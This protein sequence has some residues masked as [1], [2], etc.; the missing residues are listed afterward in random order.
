MDSRSRRNQPGSRPDFPWYNFPRNVNT[1]I[2]TKWNAK[3]DW[4]KQRMVHVPAFVV[5]YWMGSTG[6][7]EAMEPF[8]DKVFE[9]IHGPF[10]CMGW[11]RIFQIQETVYKELVMEFLST[12]SFA[13]KTGIYADDNLTFCLGGERRTLSLADFSIRIGI[14]LP[15]EVDSESYQ[16]YI[17]DC[18]RDIEGFKAEE[19]WYAIANDN[20]L[21]H[22]TLPLL[23]FFLLSA[24]TTPLQVAPSI[25]CYF[26]LRFHLIPA[27][28]E[29]PSVRL[30]RYWLRQASATAADVSV[31]RLCFH[32]LLP[33]LTLIQL[34]QR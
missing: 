18:V 30:R 24:S 14:Y 17:A 16:Q 21:P 8:L 9:S 26:R 6:L 7:M 31:R 10:V 28:L 3:L 25:R 13:R 11:R 4:V 19:H 15:S 2:Y 1:E 20:Q 29:P 34:H 27:L 32:Q 33:R 5:W 22:L 23:P 12:V